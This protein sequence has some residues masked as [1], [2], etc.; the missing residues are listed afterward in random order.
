MP[1]IEMTVV[2]GALTA[3]Q[4]VNLARKV[5]ELVVQE[6]KQP[7]EYTWVIIHDEPLENLLLG[8]LTGQEVKAKA[9]QE[10]K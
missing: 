10:K 5:T 6:S 3:E 8:G 9:M 1:L 4:K 7:K 2:K